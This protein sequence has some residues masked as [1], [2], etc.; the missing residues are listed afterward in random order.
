MNFP[1]CF[2]LYCSISKLSLYF[3]HC[4]EPRSFHVDSVMLKWFGPLYWTLPLTSGY[5]RLNEGT[6]WK[7]T[8]DHNQQRMTSY[9][10]AI[11]L[12]LHCLSLVPGFFRARCS[13]ASRLTEKFKS[14]ASTYVDDFY[15]SS[16]ISRL[17]P[18]LHTN[19]TDSSVEVLVCIIHGGEV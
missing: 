7:F 6:Y 10:F 18:N 11:P 12:T 16:L 9:L 8:L 13:S 15:A 4:G 14:S 3:L 2:R 5:I 1:N 17:F 19:P